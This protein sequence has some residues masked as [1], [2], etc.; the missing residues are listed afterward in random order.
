[1]NTFKKLLSV[2]LVL[3]M[4]FC[5]CAC[6]N[7]EAAVE[8]GGAEVPHY[9]CVTEPTFPPFDSTDENG[10]FIGFDKDLM[11]AV[12]EDQGFTVEYVCLEFDALIPALQSNQGQIITAGMNSLV[13]ERA[14][15]V[16]FCT[17]YYDSGLILMV[18]K[19]SGINGI[20]DLTP[21]MS[22]ASQ[23]GTTGGELT[24]KLYDEGKIKEAVVLG[25]YTTCA[26]QL[27][28]GAVDAVWV[29]YAVGGEFV[30][31]YDDLAL[32]REAQNHEAYEFAVQKGNAELLQKINDGL[33]NLKKNGTYDQLF[34]KW[35]L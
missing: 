13:P 7:D 3:T 15:K 22:V 24:Q 26:L 8:D 30:K 32:V 14:E 18:K 17:P 21:D 33:A 23:I 12:A 34:A 1:M 29:D 5:F 4:V 20:D 16:D 11:D 35:G 19:D 6:G 2:L 9:I 25:Q 28:S 27:E 31:A 10:E